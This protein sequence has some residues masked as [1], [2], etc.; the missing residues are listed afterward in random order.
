MSFYEFGQHC[1]NGEI[2]LVKINKMSNPQDQIFEHIVRRMTDDKALDAPA[3][4]IKYAKNLYR[5]RVAQPDASIIRRVLAVIKMDLAPNRA[6]FGER[7]A[8]GGQARQILI[9]SG[10]NAVDIR[11]TVSGKKFEIRGQVLGGGFENGEVV[12]VGSEKTYRANL[13]LLSEFDLSNVLAGEYSL[14]I[15]N[16]TAEIFVEQIILK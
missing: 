1:T 2:D 5:M 7:S 6:A 13:G 8:A 16:E 10:N 15:R 11:I 9:E 4:A 3:D 14:A 12:I